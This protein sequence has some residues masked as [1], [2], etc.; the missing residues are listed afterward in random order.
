M[1][2]MNASVRNLI[3]NNYYSCSLDNVPFIE[4][5]GNKYRMKLAR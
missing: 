5:I 4:L 2:R 3:A 1:F